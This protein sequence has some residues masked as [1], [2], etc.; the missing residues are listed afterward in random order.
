M[1]CPK[2]AGNGLR[3]S[4][5]GGTVGSLFPGHMAVTLADGDCI[6]GTRSIWCS[7]PGERLAGKSVC[8]LCTGSKLGIAE[9]SFRAQSHCVQSRNRC[10]PLGVRAAGGCRYHYFCLDPSEPMQVRLL[11]RVPS[12]WTE[13]SDAAG[14]QA[15]SA[16]P[17]SQLPVGKP[18]PGATC[19]VHCHPR[20]FVDDPSFLHMVPALWSEGGNQVPLPAGTAEGPR[21][22]QMHL[23]AQR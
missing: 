4:S 17:M 7:A 1:P 11:G 21:A 10:R 13:L 15:A 6:L 19:C 14:P 3:P 5:P 9:G 2:D 23:R 8:R 12:S 18:E 20:A 22:G 16:V